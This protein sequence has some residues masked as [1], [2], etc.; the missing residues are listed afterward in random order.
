MGTLSAG[1]RIL[2]HA[3]GRQR[4]ACGMLF[5]PSAQLAA[6]EFVPACG[7]SVLSQPVSSQS[8]GCD[9]RGD[10]HAPKSDPWQ[11]T[12]RRFPAVQAFVGHFLPMVCLPVPTVLVPPILR[13]KELS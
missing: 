2:A 8:M 13:S 12:V 9:V 10:V 1:E 11:S 4:R 7:A 5:T 3:M 6:D